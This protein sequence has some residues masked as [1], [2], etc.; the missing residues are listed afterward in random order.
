V[1]DEISPNTLAAWEAFVNNPVLPA[2]RPDVTVGLVAVDEVGNGW[3]KVEAYVKSDDPAAHACKLD[4]T[5]VEPV[6]GIPR[7]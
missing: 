1:G 3:F 6:A 5:P 2:W 7:P 4:L